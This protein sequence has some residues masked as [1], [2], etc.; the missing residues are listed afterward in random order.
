MPF[1]TPSSRSD[2]SQP[3][4]NAAG[5]EIA[6]AGEQIAEAIGKRLAEREDGFKY[7]D[8]DEEKKERSPDAMQKDV[9]DLACV[10]GRERGLVAGTAADLR[11]PGVRA[12]GVAEDGKSERLACL[13]RGRF[14]D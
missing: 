7:G 8:D 6:H 3:S 4:G 13:R 5:G 2:C 12:G 9:V 14:A 10:L 1:H 11:G